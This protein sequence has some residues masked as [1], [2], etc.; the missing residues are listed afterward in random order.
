MQASVIWS[1]RL[2]GSWRLPNFQYNM[3]MINK[4]LKQLLKK[5]GYQV[6]K[7]SGKFY[8]IDL[9]GEFVD[10]NHNTEDDLEAYVD[11]YIFEYCSWC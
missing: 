6:L 11:K 2:F 7:K 4:D 3:C 1:G 10:S 9:L 8:L 5:E